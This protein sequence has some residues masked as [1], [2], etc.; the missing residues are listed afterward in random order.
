MYHLNCFKHPQKKQNWESQFSSFRC[1]ISDLQVTHLAGLFK[2][3]FFIIS[4]ANEIGWLR[5]LPTADKTWT[6]RGIVLFHNLFSLAVS[7]QT[8]YISL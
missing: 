6:H 1:T 7:T 8:T 2:F 4:A 5:C 3:K